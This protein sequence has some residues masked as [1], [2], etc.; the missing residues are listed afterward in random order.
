[1]QFHLPTLMENL[2]LNWLPHDRA[3]WTL[4]DHWWFKRYAAIY[5]DKNEVTLQI[6]QVAKHAFE[7]DP[8][9]LYDHWWHREYGDVYHGNDAV[10]IQIRETAKVAFG[11][12]RIS[13]GRKQT[14]T[15]PALSDFEKQ[16]GF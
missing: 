7:S 16:Y 5:P 6:R 12:G 11:A 2:N 10:S 14:R 3:E 4:F 1:M 15:A 9:Y 8:W 13:R